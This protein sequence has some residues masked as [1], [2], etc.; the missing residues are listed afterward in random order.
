MT[1]VFPLYGCVMICKNRNVLSKKKVYEQLEVYLEGVRLNH[2]D[3]SLFNIFFLVRRLL[4]GLVIVGFS[5]HPFFQCSFLMVFSTIHLVYLF[6]VR[7]MS[8][9][10]ENNIEILNEFCILGCTYVLSVFLDIAAPASFFEKMGWSFMI[11]AVFNILA[12][13]IITG[14]FMLLE[15]LEECA[16]AR[17]EKRLRRIIDKRIA[18]L[19]YIVESKVKGVEHF[20]VEIKCHKDIIAMRTW[21]PHYQ[22]LK[23][24]N[25]EF[26]TWNQQRQF[27]RMISQWKTK[28]RTT[29]VTVSR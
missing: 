6:A 8:T 15:G 27:K 20:K 28:Q 10:S 26:E 1:L 11:I 7:P 9:R 5:A 19:E 29:E 14:A 18:S 17:E 13:V 22:W 24:N 16:Q 12:N 23:A 3:A 4:T 25:V 2:L 21:W